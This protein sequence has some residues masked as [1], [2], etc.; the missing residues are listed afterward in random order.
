MNILAIDTSSPSG[1][2]ALFSDNRLVAELTVSEAGVHAEWLLKSIDSFLS[3]LNRSISEVD[4]FAVT[5]GPGSFTGIRIGV[6]AV[7][8]LAWSA[9]K[10][11][12]GVSTLKALSM[13]LPYSARPVCAVLDA[14]KGEVYSALFDLSGGG[15]KELMPEAALSPQALV[16]ALASLSLPSPPIFIGDGLKVYGDLLREKVAL[17]SFAPEALWRIRA[18]N[19]AL[20][21]IDDF[22]RDPK[23]LIPVYLRRSEAE[24]KANNP[25]PK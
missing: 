13:N 18:S 5:N 10:K 12:A 21:A 22:H 17:A 15:I 8:G 7:K 25:K 4:L 11:A 1:S 19:I 14:R 6:S 24:I 9:G 2:I 3:S 20:L 23:D 16:D